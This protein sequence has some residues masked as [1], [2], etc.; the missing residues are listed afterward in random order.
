MIEYA[1]LFFLFYRAMKKTFIHLSQK[2]FF[3]VS[4]LFC[5]L[6]AVLD[7]FHQSFIRGRTSTVR[8]VGFDILGMLIA[9]YMINKKKIFKVADE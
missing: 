8:D 5:I 1:I 3:I 6:Y 2:R 9:Y 4:L 7:E